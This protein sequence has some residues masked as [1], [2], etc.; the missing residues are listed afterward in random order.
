MSMWAG[1]ILWVGIVRM[2]E[3]H[4]GYV[5]EPSVYTGASSVCGRG[6]VSMWEGHSA[7]V[8]VKIKLVRVSSFHPL[9]DT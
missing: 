2:W 6:I 5:G 8:E 7:Y 9:Y 3:G 1:H 4:H